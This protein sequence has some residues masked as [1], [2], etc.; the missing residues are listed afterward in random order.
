MYDSLFYKL[1]VLLVSDTSVVVNAIDDSSTYTKSAPDNFLG[2]SNIQ[3]N[4][5]LHTQNISGEIITYVVISLIGIISIVWFFLPDRFL[6]IF[7]FKPIKQIQ[8]DVDSASKAPGMFITSLFW[9]NF[10]VAL[11]IFLFLTSR[12][13]FSD[14]VTGI[15]NY[16]I[17]KYIIIAITSLVLYRFV[18]TYLTG[19]IFQTEKMMKQQIIVDRNIQLVTGILLLPIIL[20]MQ[21][22]SSEILI[23]VV[24]GAIALL[25][26]YRIAQIAIIG[27]SSSVFSA[28][29]IILYLCTLEIIPILVL[30]RLI[31]NDSFI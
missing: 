21:Y 9:L 12:K 19:Y 2:L 16:G 18:I 11:S 7:S 5:L 20:L 26:V 25:Q 31:S 22:A 13:F 4:P 6:T 23:F 30:L 10:I 15:T 14:Q 1:N 8:R 29:H 24:V 3:I 17:I 27:N 28:L